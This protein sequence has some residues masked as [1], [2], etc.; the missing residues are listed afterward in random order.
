LRQRLSTLS[1]FV[2]RDDVPTRF[3]FLSPP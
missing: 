1:C 3:S 2:P